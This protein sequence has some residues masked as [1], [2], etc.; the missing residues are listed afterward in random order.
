MA[1]PSLKLWR[2]SPITIIQAI[3]LIPEAFAKS[4]LWWLC[5]WWPWGWWGLSVVKKIGFT[6]RWWHFI[7]VR[8][9]QV[10]KDVIKMLKRLDEW[11]ADGLINKDYIFNCFNL[12]WISRSNL[13]IE[14]NLTPHPG[15]DLAL[16]VK[17]STI[18][19]AIQGMFLYPRCLLSVFSHSQSWHNG[20]F[21]A[22]NRPN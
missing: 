1:N 13:T 9:S 10:D 20:G 5:P 22:R 16:P 19:Y 7:Q 21:V 4:G 6:I 2:P 3:S 15:R 12:T 17:T 14:P 11:S 8:L 18:F